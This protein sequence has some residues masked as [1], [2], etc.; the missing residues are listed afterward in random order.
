MKRRDGK[1]QSRAMEKDIARTKDISTAW[2][3][4]GK[5]IG[6]TIKPKRKKHK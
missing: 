5:A 2:L 6:K 4:G 1:I 3:H